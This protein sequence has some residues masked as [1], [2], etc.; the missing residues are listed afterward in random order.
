MIQPGGRVVVEVVDVG[1][2]DVFVVEVI[3]SEFS[4][5]ISIF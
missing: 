1:D 3:E 4:C 5:V 2:G